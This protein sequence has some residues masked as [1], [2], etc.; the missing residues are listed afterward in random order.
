[1]LPNNAKPSPP[2]LFSTAAV[3]FSAAVFN[4][5]VTVSAILSILSVKLAASKL[6]AAVPFASAAFCANV[7]ASFAP[8]IMTA[9]NNLASE[10]SILPSPVSASFVIALTRDLINAS[11]AFCA[12]KLSPP[13]AAPC[14]TCAEVTRKF[15]IFAE[16]AMICVAIESTP[17]DVP[18]FTISAIGS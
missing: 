12:D 13:P 6:G 15:T 4:T 14:N 5:F 3:I 10:K 8:S 16:L 7:F 17:A 18:A 2:L 9:F 11:L 1:M